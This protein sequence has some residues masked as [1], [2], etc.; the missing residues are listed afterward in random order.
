MTADVLPPAMAAEIAEIIR[1]PE[2]YEADL[3]AKQ[4]RASGGDADAVLAAQLAGIA[5]NPVAYTRFDTRLGGL[6][7]SLSNLNLSAALDGRQVDEFVIGSGYHCATYCAIRHLRGKPKP[8]ALETSKIPGGV[9]AVTRNPS[10][11]LNSEDTGGMPGVPW[12]DGEPNAPNWLPGAPVQCAQISGR[13]LPDNTVPRF[14]IRAALMLHARVI[15]GASAASVRVTGQRFSGTGQPA[16]RVTLGDGRSLLAGR[17]ID[18]RGFGTER[19]AAG[20]DGKTILTWA[21]AMRQAD[22]DFAFGQMQRVAVLGDGKSAL[23]AAEALLGIG[24]RMR[25]GGAGFPRVDLYAPKLPDTRGRWL[26]EMQSRYLRLASHLPA[27]IQFHDLTVIPEKGTPVALPGGGVLVNG[28]Y[29]DHAVLC[30][31]W[32]PPPDLIV[33]SGNPLI[34]QSGNPL[35]NFK[36]GGRSAARQCG[37]YYQVGPAAGLEFDEQDGQAGITANEEKRA[38]MFRLGPRTAMLA[39][40]LD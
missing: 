19:G 13:E 28:R 26:G 18:A 25:R 21:Q 3:L 31:G 15:T 29:Y 34:V 16:M 6:F 33:Q 30:T 17:V 27:G 2:G 1:S 5:M 38:A 37:E 9:F 22:Q 10:F 39:A 11:Y 35:P 4:A 14:V 36:A 8:W 7:A 24:P 23:C 40:T 20:A 12:A 32:D